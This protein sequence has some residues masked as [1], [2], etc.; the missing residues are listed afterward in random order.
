MSKWWWLIKASSPFLKSLLGIQLI[1]GIQITNRIFQVSHLEIRGCQWETKALGNPR[2]L[3]IV[4]T[5]SK[6]TLA[7]PNKKRME[8]SK[9]WSSKVWTIGKIDTK[10]TKLI[11]LT[12]SIICKTHLKGLIEGISQLG[13]SPSLLN[14]KNTSSKRKWNRKSKWTWDFKW[15]QINWSNSGWV[16]WMTSSKARETSFSTCSLPIRSVTSLFETGL[17]TNL[18]NQRI[19]W[20]LKAITCRS[21]STKKAIWQT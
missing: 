16:N 19:L 20:A 4:L 12:F 18:F 21:S 7:S 9:F 17:C 15:R 2:C 5:M 14:F 3:C 13:F 11:D 6:S 8:S 10:T 1:T